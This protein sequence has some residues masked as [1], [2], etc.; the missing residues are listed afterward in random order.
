MT[1][2]VFI[3]QIEKLIVRTEQELASPLLERRKMEPLN[4]YLLP[5]KIEMKRIKLVQ[6]LLL[7]KKFN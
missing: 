7:L 1:C 3:D 6:M 2:L 5:G 4:D